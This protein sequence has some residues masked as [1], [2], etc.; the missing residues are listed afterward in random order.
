MSEN[1]LIKYADMYFT[2]VSGVNGQNFV[3]ELDLRTVYG[4]VS[5]FF[6]PVRLPQLLRHLML[7]RFSELEGTY[8]QITATNFGEEVDGIRSILAKDDDEWFE[9]ENNIYFGSEFFKE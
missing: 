7:E 1:A 5:V 6:N 2:D 4:G 9:T 8:V 3:L